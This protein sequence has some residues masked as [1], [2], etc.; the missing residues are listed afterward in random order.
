MVFGARGSTLA[1]MLYCS[2]SHILME[3]RPAGASPILRRHWSCVG[4]SDSM[5]M[6]CDSAFAELELVPSSG[7]SDATTAV[8][9]ILNLDCG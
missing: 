6:S 7:S 9:L 2:S 4:G 1:S 5:T 3:T 8:L